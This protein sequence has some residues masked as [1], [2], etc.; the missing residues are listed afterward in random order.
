VRRFL[1]AH[2]GPCLLLYAYCVGIGLLR[3]ISA[4]ATEDLAFGLLTGNQQPDHT[5][6]Q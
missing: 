6:D 4:P 1:I 5:R 3:K 2:D